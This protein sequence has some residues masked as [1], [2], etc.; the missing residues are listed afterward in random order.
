MKDDFLYNLRRQP[1]QDFVHTVYRDIS[2]LPGNQPHPDR[3]SRRAP[4][5]QPSLPSRRRVLALA[6]LTSIALFLLTSLF[7]PG[8]RALVQ[9]I[10]R[11]I[12][13][14]TVRETAIYPLADGY[15][16]MPDTN[17]YLTLEAARQA[18]DFKFSLPTEL[19]DRYVM[20]DE[21]IVS[22][23]GAQIHIHWKGQETRGDGLLLTVSPAHPDAEWLVGPDST[24]VVDLNG[25]EALFTRGGWLSNTESWDENI[26][27][28][29]RWTQD[30]LTYQLST[31]GAFTCPD[32]PDYQCPLSDEALIHIAASVP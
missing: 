13:D 29:V 20:L 11:Q 12:G 23:D 9:D 2:R 26:S 8:V 21:V 32:E 28:D 19:P 6:A 27:R 14:M 4:A 16:T 25:R 22:A 15:V 30:G 10:V 18:I 24:E 7:S 31:G 5:H 1:D 3:A 17:Q